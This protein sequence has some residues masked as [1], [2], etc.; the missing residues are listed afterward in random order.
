MK[1]LV[2]VVTGLIVLAVLSR[3]VSAEED[4]TME[5]D[6]SFQTEITIFEILNVSSEEFLGLTSYQENV[7]VSLVDGYLNITTT[8]NWNGVASIGYNYIENGTSVAKKWTLNVTPV[9]DAPEVLN[10]SLSGDPEEL[11]NPVTYSVSYIEVDGDAITVTWSIDNLP[12]GEGDAVTRYVF[13]DQRNLTVIIDDGN[14]GTDTMSV[15]I[16]TVP[17]EGWGDE[18][19]NTRNRIIFWVIFGSA[20][21]I[22]LAAATWVILAPSKKRSDEGQDGEEGTQK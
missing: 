9:N 7:A 1:F 2:K 16:H 13:P 14:G 8:G 10:I 18:P 4:F 17:P 5:E 20:G 3:T 15:T 22:L 12:A 11:E 6:S 19:D 21:L